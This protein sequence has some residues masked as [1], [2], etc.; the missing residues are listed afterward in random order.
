MNS[1]LLREWVDLEARKRE[2]QSEL[3]I[4]DK[5]LDGI[6]PT[7]IDEMAAA[8][9]SN[10]KATTST[11][12]DMTVYINQQLWPQVSD[13]EKLVR[14]MSE[15]HPEFVKT[16]VNNQSLAGFLREEIKEGRGIPAP[17]QG[18][19]EMPPKFSLRS[20]MAQTSSGE[21]LKAAQK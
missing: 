7:L 12:R 15:I 18:I 20:R 2:L 8:G 4:L 11:G 13:P 1:G 17:L 14:V 19:V 6:E 10:I 3:E 21:K 9:L 16:S 5:K